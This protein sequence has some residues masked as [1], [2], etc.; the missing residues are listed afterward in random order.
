MR[1]II[2]KRFYYLLLLLMISVFFTC[3]DINNVGDPSVPGIVRIV[4][5]SDPN[6]TE[7]EILGETINVSDDDSMGIKIFQGKAWSVDNNYAILF[8]SVF[9]Y[10]QNQLT[11]NIIKRE[12]NTYLPFVVFESFVPVGKYNSISMG[13]E[14]LHLIIDVYSIP[15]TLPADED[16]IITFEGDYNVEEYTVTEIIVRLQPFASMTRYR[17][18]YV[19]ERVAD[20]FDIN[21]LDRSEYDKVVNGLPYI[22]NPNDPWRP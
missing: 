10:F 3:S 12:D 5:Q 11:Y 1:N 8:P 4:L 19:F 22:I 13:M 6:D 20:I 18:T 7:M 9:D 15:L 17:D 21:Y 2:Y 16:L 14:A